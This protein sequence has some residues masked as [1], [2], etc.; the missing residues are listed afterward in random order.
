MS[1]FEVTHKLC[2]KHVAIISFV[3]TIMLIAVC[4]L[5]AASHWHV[6]N[7]KKRRSGYI[8][9]NICKQMCIHLKYHYTR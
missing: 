1:R 4:G 8:H 6:L 3:K 2:I 7:K 5:D 9:V